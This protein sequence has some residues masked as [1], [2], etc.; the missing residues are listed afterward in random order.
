[1]KNKYWLPAIVIGFLIWTVGTLFPDHALTFVMGGL[2]SIIC[3]ILLYLFREE[4]GE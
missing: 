2:T 3:G 1:M 4:E